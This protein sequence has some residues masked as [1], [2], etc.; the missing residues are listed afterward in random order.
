MLSGG[1]GFSL[2]RRLLAAATTE[3]GLKSPLQAKARST[4]Q[5]HAL[6]PFAA[7]HALAV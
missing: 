6:I 3:R 4:L 5:H 1:A 7:R 2:Q